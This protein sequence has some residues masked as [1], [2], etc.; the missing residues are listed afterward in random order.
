M[1]VLLTFVINKVALGVEIREGNGQRTINQTFRTRV[2]NFQNV[3]LCKQVFIE[4]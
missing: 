3:I 2:N 1:Q 4:R